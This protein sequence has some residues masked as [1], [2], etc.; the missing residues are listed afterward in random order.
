MTDKSGNLDATVGLFRKN[1]MRGHNLTEPLECVA[2]VS[3]LK[4]VAI[5]KEQ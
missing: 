1:L 4:K 3:L 2:L 5:D